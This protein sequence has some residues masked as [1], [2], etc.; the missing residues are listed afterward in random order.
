GGGSGYGEVSTSGAVPAELP[1]VTAAD[2]KP[3]SRFRLIGTNLGRVDIADKVTGQAKFGIDVD[4]PDM[5]Y[6]AVLRPPVPGSTAESVDETAAR[7][8]PGVTGVVRLPYGLGVVGAGFEAV[9]KG[10]A[11][12]KVTW[13]KGAVAQSYST[14]RALGEYAAIAATLSKPGVKMH[15]SGNVGQ[16]LA[17]A[18]RTFTA[19]Y[20][21]D[22]VYHAT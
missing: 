13:T 1:T 8:V 14:D 15:E 11:A 12:L 7:A 2:L 4:V 17:K 18:T 16:A 21:S 5:I 19:T 10:K 3:L 6:G 20:V 9:H 22:H